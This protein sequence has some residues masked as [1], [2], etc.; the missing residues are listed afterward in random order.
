MKESNNTYL[1]HS[2]HAARLCDMPQIQR[3]NTWAHC[4]HI[5]LL[6]KISSVSSPHFSPIEKIATRTTIP[7]SMP[8][9]SRHLITCSRGVI[10]FL[11]SVIARTSSTTSPLY[12]ERLR[13]LHHHGTHMFWISLSVDRHVFRGIC[14]VYRVW[15]GMSIND[16]SRLNFNRELLNILTINVLKLEKTRQNLAIVRHCLL[17]MIFCKEVTTVK[18]Q[19]DKM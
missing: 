6:Q 8:L 16:E 5:F 1:T 3:A 11:G 4:K 2:L 10:G 13:H 19:R 7:K 12:G 14:K 9:K 18:P 17:L 15:F